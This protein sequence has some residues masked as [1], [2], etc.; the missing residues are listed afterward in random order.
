MTL[1]KITTLALLVV[2][3]AVFAQDD[4]SIGPFKKDLTNKQMLDSI[5]STFVHDNIASCIDSLWM[6]ELASLDLYD[7]LTLDIK[8]IN[9]EH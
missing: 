6:K 7:E 5:K 4:L 9:V 3:T 8:N 2:S 1:K